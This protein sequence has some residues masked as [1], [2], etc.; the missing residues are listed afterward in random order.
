MNIHQNLSVLLIQ[1]QHK[2]LVFSTVCTLAMY[3]GGVI[4]DS[5]RKA[6]TLSIAGFFS[7]AI[8][9]LLKIYGVY[10]AQHHYKCA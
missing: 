7:P 2:N 6:H 9:R 8:Q 5:N 10:A 4:N 1:K 3:C